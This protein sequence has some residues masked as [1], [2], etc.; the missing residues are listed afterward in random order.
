MLYQVAELSS[1]WIVADVPEQDIGLVATGRRARVRINAYPEK[2]LEGVVTYVYPTLKTETRSVAVRLELANPG[3][4]LKPG[5][6]AQVEFAVGDLRKVLV[7]PV[8]S[9][10]DSGVRRVVIVQAAEGRFE[11]RDVELGGRN[12]DWVEVKSGVKD[13]ETVVVA[14]NFLIDA[15]SNLRAALGGMGSGS[16]DAPAPKTVTHKADGKLVALEGEG[17]AKI[18]HGPVESLKWPSMTMAFTLANPA[19]AANVKPGANIH[20]EFVERKPGEWV[21]TSITGK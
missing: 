9:V 13:G 16:K 12:D 10:I 7:V 8:S 19:L 21:I 18:T 15:E 2:R 1:V 4:L 6:Y 11:P 14:A 3:G 20:F 5:M 17:M